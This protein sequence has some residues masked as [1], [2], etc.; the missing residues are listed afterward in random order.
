MTT[1]CASVVERRCTLDKNIFVSTNIQRQMKTGN[2][3]VSRVFHAKFAESNLC[4]KHLQTFH[5]HRRL[6]TIVARA[7]CDFRFLYLCQKCILPHFCAKMADNTK[8]LKD[9]HKLLDCYASRFEQRGTQLKQKITRHLVHVY[10]LYHARKA[11]DMA[12][13]KLLVER[14]CPK[15]DIKCAMAYSI[16]FMKKRQCYAFARYGVFQSLLSNEVFTISHVRLHI[17]VGLT[18]GWQATYHGHNVI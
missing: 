3:F 6:T 11:N 17:V 13:F 12:I 8:G 16:K 18:V 7:V 1:S 5:G 14:N 15:F 10:S 4:R 9:L 2:L